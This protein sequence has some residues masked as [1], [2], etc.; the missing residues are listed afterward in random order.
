MSPPPPEQPALENVTSHRA[1]PGT[2]QRAGSRAGV[3]TLL[4]AALAVGGAIAQWRPVFGGDAQERERPFVEPGTVGQRVS[5]R[6]FDATVLDVR[7]AAKVTVKGLALDT[8]GVWIVL[9][10]RLS[11][12]EEVTTI[13]YAALWDADN[14]EYRATT[15]F[16]QPLV[17]VT[18]ELQ[19]GIPVEGEIAFELPRDAATQVVVQFAEKRGESGRRMDGLAEVS[20]PAVDRATVD[21]WATEPQPVVLATP[22]VVRP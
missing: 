2:V 6:V 12:R 1:P 7:G 9:R 10:V 3:A 17:D 4:I 22:T 16:S 8:A 11:T 18:R 5:T 13:G 14:R 15:R 19:P 21:R 20:L